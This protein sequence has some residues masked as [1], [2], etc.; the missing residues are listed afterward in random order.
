MEQMS[1]FD[2]LDGF[3]GMRQTDGG[4]SMASGLP[5]NE[6]QGVDYTQP[7]ANRLRPKTLDDFVGQEHLLGQGDR[8]SVV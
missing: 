3:S 7:L 4:G 5:V 6:G 8:K 2:N 1:L